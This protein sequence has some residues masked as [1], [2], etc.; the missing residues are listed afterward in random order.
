[1]H[2]EGVLHALCMRRDSAVIVLGQ[3]TLNAFFKINIFRKTRA[4]TIGLPNLQCLS[5][6]KVVARVNL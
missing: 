4:T 5:I 2:Y 6:F 3:N 1:M